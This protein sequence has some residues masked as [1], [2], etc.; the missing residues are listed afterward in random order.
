MLAL[1]ACGSDHA[2]PDAAIIPDGPPDAKVFMDAPFPNY[3]LTCLGQTPPADAPPAITI[4]GTTQALSEAGGTIAEVTLDVF[5]N[6]GA[7]SLGSA[8]SDSTGAFATGNID[9]EGTAIDGYVRAVGALDDDDAPVH[10]TTYLYPPTPVAASLTGV[11][12]PLM[13]I[14]QFNGIVGQIPGGQNDA[15]N[16]VLFFAVTDCKAVSGDLFDQT[17]VGEADVQVL[18]NGA[19]VGFKL[20]LSI[21]DPSL[22]GVYI[23]TNVPDGET[24]IV[25]KL[26]TM[27]FPMRRVVAHKE[28][29]G[30]GSITVTIVR[31][32]P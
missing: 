32:G 13:S 19:A 26:G 7:T 5:R 24:E 16:G 29:A 23:V 11:P 6:G 3:D 4:A 25:T 20:G 12:V 15:D 17:L 30:V 28:D 9:T 1:A 27:S 2:A 22:A 14:A 10:R 8:T 21:V 31:P 18:Q